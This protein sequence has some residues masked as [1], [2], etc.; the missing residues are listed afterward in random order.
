MS[1]LEQDGDMGARGVA[2][3]PLGR[4]CGGVCP[5]LGDKPFKS[6]GVKREQGPSVAKVQRCH[7]EQVRRQRG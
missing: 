5:G 1:W 4:S 3:G 6:F 7:K 2:A